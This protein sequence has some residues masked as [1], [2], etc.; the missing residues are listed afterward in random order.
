MF[1]LSGGAMGVM[2]GVFNLNPTNP[3]FLAPL[4]IAALGSSLSAIYIYG[5]QLGA[6]S[7]IHRHY[8][9]SKSFANQLMWARFQGNVGGLL[10]EERSKKL[11]EA[12]EYVIRCHQALR[13]VAWKSAP[14]GSEYASVREKIGDAM[15]IAMVQ[16]V[17]IMGRGADANDESLTRLLE[18]MKRAAEE[19]THTA[20]RLAR[21]PG[22]ISSGNDL[23]QALSELRTLSAAQ[24]EIE[25]TAE[26][27]SL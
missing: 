14:N 26:N 25:N 11:N 21:G 16:A 3:V 19:A 27:Y 18:E 6:R 10:G 23:R 22:I 9:E 15:D 17:G 1:G 13:S 20:S 8:A 4:T 24:D 2:A 12:A 7:S 5:K